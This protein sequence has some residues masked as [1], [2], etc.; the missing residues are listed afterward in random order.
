M[1]GS[2]TDC[3]VAVVADAYEM[4]EPFEGTKTPPNPDNPYRPIP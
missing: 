4:L 1:M 3:V 2:D